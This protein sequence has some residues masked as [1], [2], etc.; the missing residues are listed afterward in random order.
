[1][2]TLVRNV[3]IFAS[4]KKNCEQIIELHFDTDKL[5]IIRENR[6]YSPDTTAE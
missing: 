2:D 3:H 4:V 5:N 1:M 6:P